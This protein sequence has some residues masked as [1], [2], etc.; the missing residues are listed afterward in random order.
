MS[1]K[2][3]KELS[4]QRIKTLEDEFNYGLYTAEE[5]DQ[6]KQALEDAQE[7]RDKQIEK[8]KEEAEKKKFLIEQAYAL[9]SIVRETAVGGWLQTLRTQHLYH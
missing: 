6:K 8:Q 1:A 7:A 3:E 2:R 9:A 4:D 5:Y